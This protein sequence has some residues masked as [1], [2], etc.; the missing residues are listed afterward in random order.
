M[1]IVIRN[2]I[3]PLLTELLG[4]IE[5]GAPS[6]QIEALRQQACQL[7]AQLPD[8]R[9][10]A[11]PDVLK[12]I[13]EGLGISRAE[14]A[15]RANIH[16]VMPRRYEEPDSGE[17][18]RPTHNTFEAINRA[19]GLHWDGALQLTQG[20]VLESEILL[21]D[22]SIEQ[23]VAELHRRNIE[24]SFTFKARSVLEAKE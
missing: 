8:P 11:F 16:G 7:G 24:P 23:L 14:L 6:E 22:A 20:E 13:R 18:A 17:F 5:N 21:K 4:A 10:K 1:P 15:K 3:H 19:L 9:S 2:S 12:K